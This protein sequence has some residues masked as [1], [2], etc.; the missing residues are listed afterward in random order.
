M[1]APTTPARPGRSAALRCLALDQLTAHTVG[2]LLA[3]H[4]DCLLLKGPGLAVR[5]YPEDP[6]ARVY[7]DVDVLVRPG[8][9]DAACRVLVA[10][11]YRWRLQGVGEG[12]FPWYEAPLAAPPGL[13]GAIDLHRGFAGVAHPG[14]LF[15]LLGG[16]R[17]PMMVG[18]TR[19][20]VP[21]PVGST[22]LVL[23]HAA[24]PGK[25]RHPKVDLE[26]A[27]ALVDADTWL[28]AVRW[29]RTLG[30]DDALAAAIDLLSPARRDE[31]RGPLGR[32]GSAVPAHLWLAGRQQSRIS[33]NLAK[34][35]HEQHGPRDIARQVA[36]RVFPSPAFLALGDPRA[37]QGPRG[38]A[39]AYGSRLRRAV[40][41]APGAVR[42]LR[43]ARRSG[44]AITGGARR[45]RSGLVDPRRWA[46]AGWALWSAAV[47]HRRLRRTPIDQVRVPTPPRPPRSQ[48]RGAITRALRLGRVSCLPTALVWQEWHGRL[49]RPRDVV[50]GVRHDD[51]GAV[52]A[53]AWLDGQDARGDFTALHRH[54]W[55]GSEER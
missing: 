49:G 42:D 33:V 28:A 52:R 45:R 13:M 48:D 32:T 8:D 6:A 39:L 21:G 47:L 24:S 12:E 19:V 55:A 2:L 44:A 9:F 34:V 7:T 22:L 43:R 20:D 36:R 1:T 41:G 15:D 53:H 29:G 31:L 11:G 51:G 5:L 38:L 23:L 4:I 16:E 25:A 10:A 26:R 30:A 54:P 35:L 37:T 50:V 3:N 14:K 17:E 27:D 18:G 46:A 40:S